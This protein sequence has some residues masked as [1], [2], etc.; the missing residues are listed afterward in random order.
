MGSRGPGDRVHI[1]S[2]VNPYPLLNGSVIRGKLKNQVRINFYIEASATGSSSCSLH[3]FS[4][5]QTNKII[6]L[7]IVKWLGLH[8]G[9]RISFFVTRRCYL[10]CVV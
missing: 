10:Y 3:L 1:T 5:P 9:L 4:R 8:T 2:L 6:G 7:V